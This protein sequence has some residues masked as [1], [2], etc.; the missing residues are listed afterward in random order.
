MMGTEQAAGSVVRG[1]VV[2]VDEH[3]R[4]LGPMDKLEAHRNGGRLHRAFSVFLYDRSGRHLLQRRAT[5]KYHFGGLWSNACCSHP[6]VGEDVVASA[7]RRLAEELGIRGVALRRVETFLYKAHDG[8][9][10]LTEHELDHVLVGRFDG[11]PIPN[12][13]EVGEWRWV[14]DAALRR[15]MA[16][17]PERFTPWFGIALGHAPDPAAAAVGDQG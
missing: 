10:G 8:V 6:G 11:E 1:E 12:P 9:S 16:E 7:E 15:E 17:S 13:G 14:D 4:E 5:G 2:L 3:D